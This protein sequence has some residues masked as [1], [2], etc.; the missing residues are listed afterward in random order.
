M[1]TWTQGMTDLQFN[2]Q[3]RS[4]SLILEQKGRIHTLVPT[5]FHINA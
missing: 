4:V 1:P 5:K 3:K 2:G